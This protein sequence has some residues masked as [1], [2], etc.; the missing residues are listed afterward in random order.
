MPMKTVKRLSRMIW[1]MLAAPL[2]AGADNTSLPAGE[3]ALEHYQAI[4]AML[5]EVNGPEDYDFAVQHLTSIIQFYPDWPEP[6]Y[7]LGI[8]LEKEGRLAEAAEA[9]RTYLALKPDAR[10]AGEVAQLIDRLD[11]RA[12]RG[13]DLETVTGILVGLD[14]ESQW[15]QA[16]GNPER[17]RFLPVFRRTPNG[18][19]AMVEVDAQ[20]RAKE[21][22]PI[23]L[24]EG[25]RAFWVKRVV[26]NFAPPEQGYT[27]A[28]KP[29][30]D[31]EV[32]ATVTVRSPGQATIRLVCATVYDQRTLPFGEWEYLY[33]RR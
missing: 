4:V 2:L 18:L 5:E 28:G 17:A 1:L 32:T 20:S 19:V 27:C 10:N 16:Y 6:Y 14:D 29:L 7:T 22:I 33:F 3:K 30:C 11:D 23:G 13:L 12:R 8:V 15:K 31:L 9:L 24:K 21:P 26:R 25:D